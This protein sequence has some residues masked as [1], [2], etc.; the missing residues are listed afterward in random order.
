MTI[1]TIGATV[2][3][4]AGQMQQAQAT[5]ASAKYNAQ[6]G[7]MNA[8]LADRRAKDAVERGAVEEQRK[9]QEV[10]KIKGAQTAAMAANGVDLS[11]GSP[12]D[13]LVDTAVLGEL[14]ALTIRTNSYRESYEHKVD[15]V[16]KRA[17]AEMNRAA[18]K[19]AIQGGYLSAAG[20]VLTGGSKAYGSYQKS[21]IGSIG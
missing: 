19:S 8:T 20:T 16:N 15:A 10:A 2:V 6:V 17:G 7:E 12:L 3:G 18:A 4:A 21:Q 14:D 11:F 5:A 9:R 13:T 1:L